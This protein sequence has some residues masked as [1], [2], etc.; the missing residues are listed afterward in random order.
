MPKRVKALGQEAKKKS[1]AANSELS[2]T[3]ARSFPAALGQPGRIGES[4]NS[5]PAGEAG[6]GGHHEC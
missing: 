3:A 6:L 4:S 2:G 5:Q 1:R